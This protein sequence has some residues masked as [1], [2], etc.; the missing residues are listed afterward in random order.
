MDRPAFDP[1]A[2]VGVAHGFDIDVAAVRRRQ[3]ELMRQW[4]PDRLA[5]AQAT[6]Q[7]T[8]MATTAAGDEELAARAAA[9]NA[10]VAILVDPARRVDALLSL[11]DPAGRDPALAP[12]LLVRALQARVELADGGAEARARVQREVEAERAACVARCAAALR[13]G[14]DFPS[15]RAERVAWRYWDR[16]LLAC[17]GEESPEAAFRG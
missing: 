6:A 7:A 13:A 11:L 16:L 9:V 2:V 12:E 10:A 1:F 4:H 14:S 15:A 8:A 3:A 17:R 5:Q